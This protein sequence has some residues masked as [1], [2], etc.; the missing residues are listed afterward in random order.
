MLETTSRL[1][2]N[3]IDLIEER[4]GGRVRY[5]ALHIVSIQFGATALDFERKFVELWW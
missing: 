3:F 5:D 1:S 4:D 2:N